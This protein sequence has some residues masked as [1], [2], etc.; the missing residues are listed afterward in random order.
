M[1]WTTVP[2]QPDPVE[3]RCFCDKKT[4]LAV[5][6]A[7]SWG[8]PFLHV[9]A[10]KSVGRDRPPRL[11]AE[12]VVTVGIVRLRCRDCLRWHKVTIRR[13]TLDHKPESLPANIS[14]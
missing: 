9:K 8:R 6:G 12:V 10:H 14:L 4:L 1:R 5:A 11:F 2:T 13:E 3:V 7:D